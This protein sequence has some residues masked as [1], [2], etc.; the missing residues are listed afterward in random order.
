MG[1]KVLLTGFILVSLFSNPCLYLIINIE[2]SFLSILLSLN[3]ILV[4]LLAGWFLSL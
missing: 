1:I 4:L 3:F 2:D